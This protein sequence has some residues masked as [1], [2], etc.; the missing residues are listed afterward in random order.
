MS[1]TQHISAPPL[2]PPQ[3]V[4]G[5]RVTPRGGRALGRAAGDEAVSVVV[6]WEISPSAIRE[7][8]LPAIAAMN[9]QAERISAAVLE[10][11]VEDGEF[12]AVL[13]LELGEDD[14]VLPLIDAAAARVVRGREWVH[15]DY[16]DALTASL[17]DGRLIYARTGLLSGLLGLP[18]GVYQAPVSG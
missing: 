5:S 7:S 15:I 9:G 3:A 6:R 4:A 14:L 13:R 12:S 11:R 1:P 17:R 16:G 10:C 18:G 8:A 2:Q